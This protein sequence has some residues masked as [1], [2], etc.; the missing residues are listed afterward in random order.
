MSAST[1]TAS[2]S[3]YPNKLN[4]STANIAGPC[5]EK[6]NVAQNLVPFQ[7]TV[8]N[9]GN[10]YIQ[11][12]SSTPMNGTQLSVSNNNFTF[13]EMNIAC[14]SIN[15][16]N[17]TLQDAEALIIFRGSTGVCAICVPMTNGGG[18]NISGGIT[19]SDIVSAVA[20]EASDENEST[21]MPQVD[22]TSLMPMN[23]PF[24]FAEQTMGPNYQITMLFTPFANAIFL[25]ESTLTTLQKL[26]VTDTAQNNTS[27]EL[28][29]FVNEQGI[30]SINAQDMGIAGSL[31]NGSDAYM[32]CEPTNVSKDMTDQSVRKLSSSESKLVK[33][34]TEMAKKYH[35][36]DIIL[37]VFAIILLILFF[38]GFMAFQTYMKEG[39]VANEA[40]AK[41]ARNAN[42]QA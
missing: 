41:A 9:S 30:G 28:Q 8:A 3:A 38:K 39:D 34:F 31:Q 6:C 1:S 29:I 36:K 14:P 37:G 12:T 27:P 2:T 32:I 21:T 42:N 33:E 10:Q 5:I 19:V 15:V 7:A 40:Q 24:Y 25:Q 13:L 18:T 17:G 23:Q 4:I 35:F 26:I 20:N 11:L 16:Y 22:L